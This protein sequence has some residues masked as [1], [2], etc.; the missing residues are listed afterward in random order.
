MEHQGLEHI[1]Q[2]AQQNAAEVKSSKISVSFFL[3]VLKSENSESQLQDDRQHM[4]FAGLINGIYIIV[5]YISKRCQILMF[6]SKKK[7][8][9]R[10]K[11]ENMRKYN[12]KHN[13]VYLLTQPWASAVWRGNGFFPLPWLRNTIKGS[14]GTWP[15]TLCFFLLS[16]VSSICYYYLWWPLTV[17]PHPL[18]F[19]ISE[20]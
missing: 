7:K 11:L 20:S 12:I 6:Y 15:E 1:L 4:D 16:E 5:L 17:Q 10:K 2:N 14:L 9:K 8:E 18:N 19:Y 3:L 13:L